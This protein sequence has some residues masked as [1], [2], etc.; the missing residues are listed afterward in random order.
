MRGATNLQQI[1]VSAFAHL[2]TTIGNTATTGILTPTA[3]CITRIDSYAFA[4]S[5]NL[6]AI[7]GNTAGTLL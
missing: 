4:D 2:P 7:S 6:T 3:A 5:P 1:G